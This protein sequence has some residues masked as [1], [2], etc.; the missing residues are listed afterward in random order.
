MN[1]APFS[2]S[3]L[4]RAPSLSAHP[5]PVVASGDNLSL[6]CS[7]EFTSGTFHLLKEGGAD[8]PQ[9]VESKWQPDPG[10][11][12][13]LFPMGP[14]STS[15]GGTYRCYGSPSSDVY[16]WSQPSDPLR[17]EVTGEG[18][19]TAQSHLFPRPKM[20]DLILVSSGSLGVMGVS[21]TDL[22]RT[23]HR[24]EAGGGTCENSAAPVSNVGVF[25]Q[26]HCSLLPRCVQ[27]ALPLSPAGHAGAAWRPPDPP[28]SL[29]GRL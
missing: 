10:R 29:R 8:P 9:Q 24:R 6:S 19:T 1:T 23:D 25:P 20:T 7:S 16:R 11:W 17:L 26:C 27:G 28:V 13:A 12:Q 5:S 3:G 18:T 2:P 15:H 4:Y 22:L 21:D 14:T